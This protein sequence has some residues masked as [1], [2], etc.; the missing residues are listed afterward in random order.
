MFA[1]NLDTSTPDPRIINFFPLLIQSTTTNFTICEQHSSKHI[2]VGQ[3]MCTATGSWSPEIS[4]HANANIESEVMQMSAINHSTYRWRYWHYLKPTG[5]CLVSLWARWKHSHAI[6][7]RFRM[8]TATKSSTISINRYAIIYDTQR[9]FRIPGYW[10]LLQSHTMASSM[11]TAQRMRETE[12]EVRCRTTAA[13]IRLLFIQRLNRTFWCS[14]SATN[15]MTT[16]RH[17]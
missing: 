10:M 16:A 14:L 1:F 7:N 5:H 2:P 11:V 6:I 3:K 4:F 13:V 17:R 12:T 8:K 9:E 15:P